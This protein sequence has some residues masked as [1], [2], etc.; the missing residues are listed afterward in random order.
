MLCA[1]CWSSEGRASSP[2]AAAEGVKELYVSG[3]QALARGK[4]AQAEIDFRRVIAL[5]P[6]NAGAYANLGVAEM[7]EKR[8]NE[9]LVSLKRAQALAPNVAGIQLNIG[10]VYYRQ[11]KYAKAIPAFQAVVTAVPEAVQPRYLLGLCYFYN[12]KYNEALDRL[13]PLWPNESADLGYL[14]VLSVA[15]DQTGHHS[16]EAKAATQ[17][18]HVGAGSPEMHLLIGKAQLVR[19][20]NESALGELKTAARA[21]S[22]LPYVHFYL[23][24]AYRRL[25][26]F[27]AAKSEFARALAEHPDSAYTLDELGA[28]SSKL[29]QQAEAARYYRAALRIDSRLASS[30]Y[31]L[32]SAELELKQYS[33]ALRQLNWAGKIDPQSASVH[34]LKGRVLLAMGRKRAAATEFSTAETMQRTVNDKLQREIS[35]KTLPMP[36]PAGQNP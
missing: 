25:D 35:G 8:W 22:S 19:G 20:A 18:L 28:V 30:H 10:L 2:S 24:I 21:D 1:C 15:A 7:R 31:G 16:L 17:L 27:P 14:Y 34:Y 9:A 26:N 33:S 23:G 29:H 4:N 36:D 11:A 32:A 13:T 6:A 12:R 5:D 3:E